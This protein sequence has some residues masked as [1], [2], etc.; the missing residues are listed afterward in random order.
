MR[1]T[2]STL[3]TKILPSPILPV[4][5]ALTIESMAPST[6]SVDDDLD[7]H[8]GQEIDD[9][10]GAAIQLGMPL[11]TTEALDLRDGQAGNADFRQAPRALRRV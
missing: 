8:L 5:A 11:L 9:I 1:T 2:C 10:L 3:E 4:R 7:L 6:A